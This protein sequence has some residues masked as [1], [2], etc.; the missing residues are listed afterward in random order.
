MGIGWWIFTCLA[1]TVRVPSGWCPFFCSGR[2]TGL[3]SLG[4]RGWWPLIERIEYMVEREFGYSCI[5]YIRIYTIRLDFKRN[6]REPLRGWSLP[7]PQSCVRLS[8]SSSGLWVPGCL[9]L[10]VP[11]WLLGSVGGYPGR[12]PGRVLG[13]VTGQVLGQPRLALWMTGCSGWT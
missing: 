3:W 6:A 12:V 13:Q 1:S 9:R 5:V 11:G 10:W 4:R 8:S 7:S 2:C